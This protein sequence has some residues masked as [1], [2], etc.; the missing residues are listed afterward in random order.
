MI[1]ITHA[2]ARKEEHE[3]ITKK[4]KLPSV[5]KGGKTFS[6]E[7]STAVTREFEGSIEELLEDLKEQE[8]R[9]LDQQTE[10]EL[11]QYRSLLQK[12]IKSVL[13]EGLR[14]KVLK[15][16][17]KNWGDLVI[18]E[19]IDAKILEITESI[20]RKN[21]AFNLLKSIEEIRGLLLDLIY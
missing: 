5:K 1:E 17:K 7:L 13:S 18:I 14:E 8:K 4:G 10:Y 15:R 3:K 21:K 19:K 9:F 11:G 6:S 2:R 12:V 16:R 20:T